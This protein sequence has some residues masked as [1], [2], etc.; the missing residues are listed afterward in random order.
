MEVM[1]KREGWRTEEG[2]DAGGPIKAKR[3]RWKS[4]A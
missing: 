2:G 1:I 3:R 4:E